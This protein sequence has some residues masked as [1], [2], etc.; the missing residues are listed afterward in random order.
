MLRDLWTWQR[1]MGVL[2]PKVRRMALLR[3]LA[4]STMNRRLGFQM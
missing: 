1:W 2:A 4:P 3:A